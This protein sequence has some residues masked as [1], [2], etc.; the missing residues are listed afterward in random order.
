M[1]C[2]K[3]CLMGVVLLFF[4]VTSTFALA[5]N[6]DPLFINLTSSNS[7]RATMAIGFGLSQQERGHAVTIFLNDTSVQLASKKNALNYKKQQKLLHEIVAHKGKVIVC[8]TC[9]KYYGV[10]EKDLI[11]G[12]KK[13]NP[14][15]TGAQLFKDHTRTMAW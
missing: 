12:L 5:A 13:G 1:R 6:T 3:L 11:K 8:P 10:S 14:D 15:M 7:H 9:M 4:G 2:F